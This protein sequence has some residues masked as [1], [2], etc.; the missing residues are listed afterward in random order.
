[1]DLALESLNC[2]WR[3]NEE[4]IVSKTKTKAIVTNKAHYAHFAE[5]IEIFGC[6]WLL[7][8]CV[9]KQIT[10]RTLL[11]LGRALQ[12]YQNAPVRDLRYEYH[13]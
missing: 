9:L 13:P 5:G 4:D 7:M 2:I 10:F 12:N 3:K 8:L 1:V 11:F 6:G